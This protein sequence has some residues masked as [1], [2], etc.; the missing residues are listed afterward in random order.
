[1]STIHFKLNLNLEFSVY[2]YWACIFQM[3]NIYLVFSLISMILIY[4][5]FKSLNCVIKSSTY[6]SYINI[7]LSMDKI[8]FYDYIIEQEVIVTNTIIQLSIFLI[9]WINYYNI[10]Y[11]LFN[12]TYNKHGKPGDMSHFTPNGRTWL[13]KWLKVKYWIKQKFSGL[14]ESCYTLR[15]GPYTLLSRISTFHYKPCRD[16]DR[17]IFFYTL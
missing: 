14:H 11:Y 4:L 12:S 9:K 2:V 13:C 15:I 17:C 1:L 16:L 5:L 7:I 3:I 10:I 8:N 6:F